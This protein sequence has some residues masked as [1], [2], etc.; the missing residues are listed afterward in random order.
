MKYLFICCEGETEEAFAEKVLAPYFKDIGVYVTPSKMKGVSN[1]EKVK[2]HVTGFCL[3]NPNS[4]VTTMIDYYGLRK[5]IPS[6]I[7]TEGDLYERV[8]IIEK[9]VSEELRSLNN[10]Y[11]N[12]VL[13]EFEGLLFSDVSAFDGIA[14]KSQILELKN[15]RRRATSPEHINDKY[16]TAPSRRILG[17]IPDYSKIQN[18][19][20][21][22]Q[23]IGIKKMTDECVHF[24]QWIS[25]LTAWGK[26]GTQ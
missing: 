15:I 2:K 7:P 10:L 6:L 18:G 4:L 25:K 17:Q 5:V 26:E 12:I 24:K 22:A 8:Q 3:S 14:N 11:F 13:H 23:R 21:I 9:K 20:E 1:F 16:E 19:I